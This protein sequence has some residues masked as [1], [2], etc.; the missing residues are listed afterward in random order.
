MRKAQNKIKG[1]YKAQQTTNFKKKKNNNNPNQ[2]ERTCFVCGQ[3]GHLAR[4]CLQ[5]KGM[6]A[7]AGQT[8]KSANVTIGNTGDGSGLHGVPPS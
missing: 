8:S 1:K 7:P 3:P 5:R 4:K 6:K 2:D